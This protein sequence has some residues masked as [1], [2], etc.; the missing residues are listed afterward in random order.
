MIPSFS[1]IRARSIDEAVRYLSLDGA[2]VH[3]GG[4]DLLG[5]GG[6]TYDVN[7]HGRHQA[8]FSRQIVSCTHFFN[9]RR[10]SGGGKVDEMGFVSGGSFAHRLTAI[11]T[12]A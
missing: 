10:G 7:K 2:R 3:A 11:Q 8:A 5:Q 4:T 1:Y 6:R 9:Q 12:E